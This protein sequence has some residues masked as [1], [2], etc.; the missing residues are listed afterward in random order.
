MKNL[1][2][3]GEFCTSEPLGSKNPTRWSEKCMRISGKINILFFIPDKHFLQ[4]HVLL[5]LQHTE[6]LK[7]VLRQHRSMHVPSSMTSFYSPAF[8][9]AFSKWIDW[10]DQG[11]KCHNFFSFYFQRKKKQKIKMILNKLH[12]TEKIW[13]S[14]LILFCIPT[15]QVAKL[16]NWKDIK[17]KHL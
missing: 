10:V 13:N 7:T 14:K 3:L 8:L 6:V 17:N 9:L 11:E 2:G 12:N 1:K 15:L 4:I 16:W 5:A